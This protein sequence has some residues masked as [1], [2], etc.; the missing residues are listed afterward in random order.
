MKKRDFLKLSSAATGR[1]GSWHRRAA[2]AYAQSTAG[3]LRVAMTA[4][5]IRLAHDGPA[6]TRA[7]K[8]SASWASPSTMASHARDLSKTTPP[9]GDR[10]RPRRE[11]V[12]S[13]RPT[14]GYG[15]SSFGRAFVFHDGSAFNADAVVWNLD[16]LLNRN[17]PQFDSNASAQRPVHRGIRPWRRRSTTTRSKS[18]RV[19]DASSAYRWRAAFMSSPATGGT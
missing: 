15:P 19:I 8:V 2:G 4:A 18:P 3:T 17:A 11:L 1:P 7:P 10:P 13:R 9:P 12:E 6:Q 14:G 16:K 5:D